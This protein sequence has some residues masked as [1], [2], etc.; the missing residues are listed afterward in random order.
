MFRRGHTPSLTRNLSGN[1]LPAAD[2]LCG[3]TLNR[4]QS[5]S[6]GP[7]QFKRISYY[8]VISLNTRISNLNSEGRDFRLSRN[9]VYTYIYQ[10][11]P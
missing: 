2:Q 9:V 5:L 8:A 1:R 7:P 4:Q 11:A 3:N 10:T 6:P